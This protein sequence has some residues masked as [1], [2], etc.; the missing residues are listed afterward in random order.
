MAAT[1]KSETQKASAKSKPTK[2]SKSS[3]KTTKVA[4]KASKKTSKK[5]AYKISFDNGKTFMTADEAIA[6][7]ASLE[8]SCQEWENI[9]GYIDGEFSNGWAG[10]CWMK[11]PKAKKGMDEFWES[12]SPDDPEAEPKLLKLYLEKYATED[13]ILDLTYDEED[14]Q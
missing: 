7:L 1:K 6:K 13:M 14:E 11:P 2:T 10:P 4:S 3:S 5:Q 8:D 9:L 12:V